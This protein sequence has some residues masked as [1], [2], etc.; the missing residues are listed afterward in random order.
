METYK[1][2]MLIILMA[3]E[4]PAAIMLVVC[5]L[6]DCKEAKKHRENELEEE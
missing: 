1:I 3:L 2:V 6:W 5:W 4:I